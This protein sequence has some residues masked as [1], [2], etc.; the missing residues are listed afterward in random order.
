MSMKKLS[1]LFYKGHL[2]LFMKKNLMGSK[3]K[4]NKNHKTKA[5]LNELE[6]QR[7]LAHNTMNF[8]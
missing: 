5:I 4:K 3:L 7:V 2:W 6:G 1:D 8:G